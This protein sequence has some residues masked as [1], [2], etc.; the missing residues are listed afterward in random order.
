MSLESAKLF[1][2]KMKTDS[3]FREKVVALKTKEERKSFVKN[4]GFDFTKEEF[5][6]VKKEYINKAKSEGELSDEDLE[7]VAGGWIMCGMPCL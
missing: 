3:E 5:E 2:E 1:I 4:E 6:Q 7:K